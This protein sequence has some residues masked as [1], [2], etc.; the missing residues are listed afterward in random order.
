MRLA[1]KKGLQVSCKEGCG[2]CCHL[3]VFI[4]EDEADL[5]AKLIQEQK[6]PIDRP[7]LEEQ[8]SR[9]LK[10]PLWS[11]MPRKDNRCIFLAEGE[12]CTIYNHRPLACRK[13]IVSSPNENCSTPGSQVETG[14][15]RD[16]E[17]I[18]SAALGVRGHSG[19]M[20]KLLWERLR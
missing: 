20:A 5:L 6:I 1:V 4:S 10:S 2:A 12:N 19:P 15:V 17:I 16:A 3:E 9:D 11:G 7:R 13:L 14:V 8:A 18:V